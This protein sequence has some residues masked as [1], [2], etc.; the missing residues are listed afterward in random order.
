MK[1]INFL[2]VSLL[3]LLTGWTKANAEVTYP[4]LVDFNTAIDVSSETFVPADGW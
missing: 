2:L 1:K 4:Y 3:A